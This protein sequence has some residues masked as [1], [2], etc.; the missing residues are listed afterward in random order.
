MTTAIPG[1]RV[2]RLAKVL[3]DVGWW[4]AIG[5]IVLALALSFLWPVITGSRY[6]GVE[7]HVSIPD[8]TAQHLLLLTSPDTLI[9]RHPSLNGVE[10]NLRFELFGVRSILLEWIFALPFFAV[11]VL[12]LFL[13][14]SFLRDVLGRQV[15]SATNARRLT[16]LGW[17][18]IG[19]GV[20]LPLLD[21]LHSAL[22]IKTAGLEGVPLSLRIWSFG[23]F[24]PGILV[25]VVAAAWRYGVEL[26]QDRDLVV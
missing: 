11:V 21:F 10:G 24:V 20:A 16:L 22:L 26:Q 8:E 15:F 17:L 14:R 7:I 13:A 25:L 5:G 23:T 4:L 3:A 9:A 12:G 18:L 1:R 19:A 6:W 2:T